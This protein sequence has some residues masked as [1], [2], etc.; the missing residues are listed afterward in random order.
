MLVTISPAKKLDISPAQTVSVTQPR[1]ME[2]TAELMD[3]VKEYGPADLK[4]LM[5]ISDKLAQLNFDR[6]SKFGEQPR[7]AAAYIFDGDTYTG[8]DAKTLSEDAQRWAQDH[9]RILSGLY[10]VLRPMDEIE[11]YRL[12]MGSRVASS[13]GKNL[14][15]FWRAHIAPL[16]A[17][18]AHAAGTDI[19]VNCASEEYFG[20]VDT[21]TL[22]LRVITPKFYDMKNGTPK[23][24][25]FYAKQ[26]R[27]AMARYIVDNRTT[28]LDDL[29]AFDTGGYTY[30]PELSSP[31]SPAFV[32]NGEG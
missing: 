13:R 24:I 7:K 10:G 26:A 27:G 18:D 22:G 32:R 21:K 1:L 3:V 29:M 20:A 15:E 25:S 5:K 31:D 30:A 11:P 6:F 19:L 2:H 23:I 17:E 4:S 9:L 8:L 12:E 14:Y 28:D 16:L